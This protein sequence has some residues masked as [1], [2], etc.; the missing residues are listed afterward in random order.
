V[1]ALSFVIFLEALQVRPERLL[2]RSFRLL[3]KGY[4]LGPLDLERRSDC[5][6]SCC[7]YSYE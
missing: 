7:L 4:Y 2:R 6:L 3:L 1:L 5:L